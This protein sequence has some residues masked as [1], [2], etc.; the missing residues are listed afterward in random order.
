MVPLKIKSRIGKVAYE[1]ILQPSSKIHPVFHVSSLKKFKGDRTVVSASVLP[2]VVSNVTEQ[3][4]I[5]ITDQ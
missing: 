1:L 3:I 2:D 5:A 4:P